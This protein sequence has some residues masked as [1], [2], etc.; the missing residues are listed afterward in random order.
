MHWC[1][2]RALWKTGISRH[3]TGQEDVCTKSKWLSSWILLSNFIKVKFLLDMAFEIRVIQ[4]ISVMNCV[5]NDPL[6][7]IFGYVT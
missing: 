4:N 1:L 7:G 5:Q 2:R 6:A 3:L